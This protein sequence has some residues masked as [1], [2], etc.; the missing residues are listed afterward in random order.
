MSKKLVQQGDVLLFKE[1]KLPTGMK[2][3]KAENGRL[4]FAKG[5]ATGHHHSVA[6]DEGVTLWKDKNGTLW[7]SVEADKATII[8]QEHKPVTVKKGNYRVG[9]VREVD[10]FAEEIRKVK[11]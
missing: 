4:I 5:E 11:D 1:E 9:L 7:A 10:P 3:M 6:V 2:K 8:H